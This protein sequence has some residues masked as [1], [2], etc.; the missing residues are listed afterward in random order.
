MGK[1]S[2]VTVG[3]YY[4]MGLHGVLGL[5]PI[6]RI[7]RLYCDN[8]PLIDAPQTGG[9]ITID[10][11]SFFSGGTIKEGLRGRIWF[12]LSGAPTFS[13]HLQEN[14]GLPADQVP[15]FGHLAHVVFGN[16][17]G[18]DK[19]GFYI[20]NQPRPREMTF[21]C[22]RTS[23]DCPYGAEALVPYA[24]PLGWGT[25][26]DFN[27]LVMAWHLL[28][29]GHEEDYGSTWAAAAA[30][31]K[32]EGFGVSVHTGGGDRDALEQE[33]CRYVD[34]R[35]YTD[36]ESGLREVQL[37]RPDFDAA[38][39]PVIGEA[40]ILSD[41]EILI[42]ARAMAVNT[43]D[44]TFSDRA[45]K[46]DAA[47][48][49]VQ[50]TAHVAAFGVRRQAVDYR[51]VTSRE[52]AVKL[53][54][55]DVQAQTGAG[56]SG[57]VRVSGLRPDL[58]EGSPFVLDLPSWG[59][60][61]VV[62]RIVKITERGPRD[63][64]VDVAFV[65]DAFGVEV[66]PSVVDD[67]PDPDDAPAA[68]APPAQ[69]ALEVPYWFGAT[70][71][72]AEFTDA[73]AASPDFGA[74]M[75]AAQAPNGL[76]M[77][78][79]I[80]VDAGTGY[81]EAAVAGTFGPAGA[82]EADVARMAT[83]LTVSPM[84]GLKVGHLVLLGGV[85]LVRVDAIATGASWTLTV[86]RGCLDTA[87]VAHAAGASL[88]G[89]ADAQAIE[90]DY[91]SGQA[92]AVKLLP[93]L[94]GDTLAL[95]DAAALP[96]TMG[97]RAIRPYPPGRFKVAGAYDD[98]QTITA[99]PVLTWVPRNRLLQVDETHAEDHDE[100]GITA[101]AGTSYVLR[102]EAFDGAGASLGVVPGFSA[103]DLGDVLTVTP[104][105]YAAPPPS[106]TATIRLSLA[107]KRDGH[108]SWTA[109]A[110]TVAPIFPPENTT[111]PVISGTATEGETLTLTSGTWS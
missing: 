5:R 68:L 48:V 87:P 49:T 61:T 45:K 73:L 78:Y 44:I 56:V 84:A 63:C 4:R 38:T 2:K 60:S 71:A 90:R 76:H 51:W 8:K 28:I 10:K 41:P 102:A 106:G 23:T 43:L 64:S 22:E 42:P 57:A 52:L 25:C 59:V 9:V 18:E 17:A 46:W 101:E 72:G 6:D 36:R 58:H 21:Y 16:E 11:G 85:E 89:L 15:S 108:E 83:S 81:A 33:I 69:A 40:D 65:A 50:D 77:G 55:R 79:D 96:V 35:P 24:H 70:R 98:G 91:T 105:L 99:D 26:H 93:F 75:T 20:G 94:T 54:F 67:V 27:P 7:V 53:G 62:C 110:I 66:A 107:A 12:Y 86:G 111:L 39:L 31:L 97:A 92:L 88:V 82:L 47:V 100:A 80:W 37:I 14:Y 34:A 95:A 109:P 1:S 30:V 3:Y 103:L 13:A 104:A 74:L 32:A 19:V 29:K